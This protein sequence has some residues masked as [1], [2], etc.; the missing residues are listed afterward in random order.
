MTLPETPAANDTGNPSTSTIR[1]RSVV[2]SYSPGAAF[3]AIVIL[4]VYSSAPSGTAVT[5]NPEII[6]VRINEHGTHPDGRNAKIEM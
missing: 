5:G 2:S 6:A 1:T 3:A 4:H